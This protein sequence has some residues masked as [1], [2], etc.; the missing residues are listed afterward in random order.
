MAEPALTAGREFTHVRI[1]IGVVT[2]LALTRLLSGLALFLTHPERHRIY[3]AH[4]AWACFMMLFTIYFWWFQFSLVT[5]ARWSFERYLFVICY[6][7]LIFL[8]SA[9]L[10]PTAEPISYDAHFHARQRLFYGLLTAIFLMD[11]ADTA[12]KG[13]GRLQDYGAPYV[14]QQLLLA[15]MA[16]AAMLVRNRWY[17]RLFALVAMAALILWILSRLEY[18]D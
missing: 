9:V 3:S 11:I 1:V 16:I 13:A 4:L 5:V 10:M 6:A 2:G 18:L 15:G 8:A 17:H 12:L 14:M 7:A